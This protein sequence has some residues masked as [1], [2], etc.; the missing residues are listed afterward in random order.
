[1]A[2]ALAAPDAPAWT[3]VGGR[4]CRTVECATFRDALTLVAEVGELAEAADHHPDIDLRYRRVTLALLTHDAGGIT[5]LDLALARDIDA[6]VA[7]T[8]PSGSGATGGRAAQ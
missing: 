3:L 4:L 8:P 1:M 7:R 2:A 6:A 5:T